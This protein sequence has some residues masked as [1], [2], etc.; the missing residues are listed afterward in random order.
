MMKHGDF[1]GLADDY[2]RFRPGY[3]R[4]CD[5]VRRY[6]GR[7]AANVGCRGHRRQRD[8]WTRMLAA[9]A[10][11]PSWR[12][13]PDD[14]MRTGKESRPRAA[15]DSVWRKE[16]GRSDGIARP[17]PICVSMA[18]PVPFR[19]LISTGRAT[20][21]TAFCRRNLRALWDAQLDRANPLRGNRGA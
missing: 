8:I 18:K 20:G 16:F 17:Q 1:T 9:A 6:L 19:R 5:G 12:W 4:R 21:C 7:D 11:V 10:Y 3:A 15:G 14:D 2:S 13:N